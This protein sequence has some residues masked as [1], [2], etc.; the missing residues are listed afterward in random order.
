MKTTKNN[1][2]SLVMGYWS[3]VISMLFVLSGTAQATAP[4]Y[5]NT[6][7]G[8]HQQSAVS[9]QTAAPT[10]SF[11]STS[12][13]SGQW[14]DGSITPMLNSDGSVN[15]GAYTGAPGRPRRENNPND[16]DEEEDDGNTPLGDGLLP[17][18]FLAGVYSGVRLY[19]KKIVASRR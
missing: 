13:Y 4:T 19:R 2:L 14:G 10:V 3:I 11:Q 6:Y 18:M 9:Y 8:S 7:K 16:P 12:A 1:N 17:L 15:G 5:R